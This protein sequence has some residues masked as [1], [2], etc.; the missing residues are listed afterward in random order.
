MKLYSA[1]VPVITADIVRTL[2]ADQDIET[3]EPQEVE[4]DL[5][6]VLGEYLRMERDVTDQAKDLL[7]RRGGDRNELGKI[8]REL[9][10]KR[11]FGLGEEGISWMLDQMLQMLMHS[12]NVQEI[13]ADDT[14]IR[15]KMRAALTRHM[16]VEEELDREVR[17]RIKN[18]TEGTAAWDV[19]YGRMMDQVK[20]K[21]GV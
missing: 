8:K 4:A 14:A 9:A 17:N 2:V 6:S 21:R 19:E 5:G 12:S 18:M 13:Y 15:R 3:E 10:E 7:E 11:G 1:K 16:A 20:R